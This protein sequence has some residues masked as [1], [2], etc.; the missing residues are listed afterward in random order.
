MVRR[1]GK[2]KGRKRERG[3][4]EASVLRMGVKVDPLCEYGGTWNMQSGQEAAWAGQVSVAR[5]LPSQARE[6]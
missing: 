6:E 5:P 4:R 1:G 3:A 2:G